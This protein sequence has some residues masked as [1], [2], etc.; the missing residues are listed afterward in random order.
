MSPQ[1]WVTDPG[2]AQIRDVEFH[3][4]RPSIY[5]IFQCAPIQAQENA[6]GPLFVLYSGNGSEHSEQASAACYPGL[7]A[8]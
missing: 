8:L 1:Q 6:R 5:K 2:D 7:G 4:Y 3:Q